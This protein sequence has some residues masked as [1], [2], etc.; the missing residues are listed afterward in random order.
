MTQIQ[1]EIKKQVDSSKPHEASIG[2]TETGCLCNNY[3]AN[4]SEQTE[5]T[6]NDNVD[7]I[8]KQPEAACSSTSFEC[9]YDKKIRCCR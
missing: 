8:R 5:C 7:K 3:G 4:K 6:S 9:S 2:E 1:E